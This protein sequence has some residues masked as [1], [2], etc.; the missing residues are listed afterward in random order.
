MSIR[1]S[2]F[3]RFGAQ[4]SQPVFDAFVQGFRSTKCSIVEHDLTAD[5]AVIWSMLWSSKMRNNQ[6]V[7][8]HFRAQNKPV[9]V[10]EVGCLARGLSWKVGINGLN[11]GCYEWS[12]NI[13]RPYFG[14]RLNELSLGNDIVICSQNPNSEQWRGQLPMDLWLENKINEIKLVTDRKIVVR[15]HP[16]FPVKL[17][18]KHKGVELV[19]PNFLSYDDDFVQSITNARCIVNFNSNPGI[20]AAICGK[21]VIVDTTSLASPISQQINDIESIKDIDRTA[22]YEN[23]RQTEYTCE[24]MAQGLIAKPLLDYISASVPQ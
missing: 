10:L 18:Y 2:I 16:R 8:H 20:L 11:K 5:A 9:I 14:Y 12:R 22:W 24:E 6:S 17:R 15:S 13:Q 4:N 21:P 1:I 23:I 3:N 19:Q 7:Y